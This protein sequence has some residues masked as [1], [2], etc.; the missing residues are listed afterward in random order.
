MSDFKIKVDCEL[1]DSLK[2]EIREIVRDEVNNLM[3][4]KDSIVTMDKTGIKIKFETPTIEDLLNK[5]NELE[6]K[7]NRY[8]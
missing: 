7:L 3:Q 6:C 4:I 5:I 2:T 8:I 1:S